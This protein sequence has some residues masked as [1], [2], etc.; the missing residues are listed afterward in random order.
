MYEPMNLRKYIVLMLLMALPMMSQAA[1]KGLK[2]FYHLGE[3]VD[4]FLLQN[5]D[6]DYIALPEH[7]WRVAYTNTMVGINSYYRTN[8][9]GSSTY[10]IALL[11]HTTPSVDLGFYAGYRGFGAGY[12][13]D[14]LNAYSHNFNLSLGSKSLGID[15]RRQVSSNISGR[16]TDPDYDGSA[17]IAMPDNLLTITNMNLTAWYAL[18]SEHYSHNAAVKQSYIQKKSAGSLLL[19]LS[20][21]YSD[22][23]V[24]DTLKV[25]DQPILSMLLDSVKS[26]T[27]HQVAVG[28]G[29]GINY[30][31]NKG[32]VV[33]HAAAT[34]QLVCYSI[35]QVSLTIADTILQKL[36]GDPKFNIHPHYPVHVT[37]NVRAAVSWEINRWVHMSLW[38]QGDHIRFQA[39]KGELSNVLMRN[40]NWHVHLN[41]GVR[42]GAGKQRVREALADDPLP[43]PKPVRATKLP[44]WITEY[45]YSP[46]L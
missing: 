4:R 11:M 26:V 39:R 38:A 27:T 2:F 7:S 21:L 13:W 8:L 20:Y 15:F 28:L 25:G 46:S 10:R 30:T 5:V 23:S 14:V 31:P 16:V 19:S 9:P 3:R 37:G 36:P 18:N 29:Y 32:K 45:F 6:T 33:L 35:N 22:Y 12:S 44:K 17:S 41:I 34:L 42:F 24:R 43:D 1:T 40:W